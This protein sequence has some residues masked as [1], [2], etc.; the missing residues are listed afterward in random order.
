MRVRYLS[1]D[2]EEIIIVEENGLKLE[3]KIF[4]I[5][6][7]KSGSKGYMASLYVFDNFFANSEV[8]SDKEKAKKEGQKMLQKKKKELEN[9]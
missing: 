6:I 4:L 7:I 9:Y 8:F 3:V 1:E 2:P 5:Q